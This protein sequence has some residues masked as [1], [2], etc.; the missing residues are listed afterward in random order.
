MVGVVGAALRSLGFDSQQGELLYLIL[1]L[2]GAAAHALEQRSL[3]W[4]KYPFF[5]DAIKVQKEDEAGTQHG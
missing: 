5:K 2:P 3:G 1:R 4:R